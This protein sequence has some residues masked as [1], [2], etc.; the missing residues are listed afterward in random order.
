[1]GGA[2]GMAGAVVL[3][4]RAALRSGAGLVHTV[5][6]GPNVSVLQA[7]VPAALAHAWGDALPK[8]D[9]LVVGPGLGANA[10]QQ[11][12]AALRAAPAVPIV[13][14]AD[15][16]NAFAGDAAAL[17]DAL[18]GRPCILTPHVAEAARLLGVTT[19]R[20][21]DERFTIGR[22]VVEATGATVLLKGTPTLIHAP[23]G[24]GVVAAVGSP[25]LAT[26]GSGD[27]LAGVLGALLAAGMAPFDAAAA[28]A[29]AHGA[30]AEQVATTAVR[31][32]TI[33]DV[34]RALRDVWQLPMA[35]LVEPVLAT[36]PAVGA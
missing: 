11:V 21:L 6:A 30:A 3:A 34:E 1:V 24:R 15:A 2:V 18:G 19:Q 26:G 4:A 7:A 27:L 35:T 36:L 23:D 13:L 28:G 8:A 9:A 20:V 17:R 33:D 10:R 12:E 29:W 31:G 25:V 32:H 22:R 14:D 16:L 5:V